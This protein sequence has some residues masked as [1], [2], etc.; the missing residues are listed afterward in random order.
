MTKRQLVQEILNVIYVKYDI[1]EDGD[2]LKVQA[3]QLEND[4]RD[5]RHVIKEVQKELDRSDLNYHM[6]VE[7]DKL[8]KINVLETAN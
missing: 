7:D 8:M 2:Q 1:H 5:V 6:N 3:S 4:R